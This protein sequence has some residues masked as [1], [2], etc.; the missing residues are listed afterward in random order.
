MP[1][2]RC[3]CKR[4]APWAESSS[5]QLLDANKISSGAPKKSRGSLRRITQEKSA[6][7][8]S[9][10]CS[11]S[12]KSWVRSSTESWLMPIQNLG[13]DEIRIRK[14]KCALKQYKID[15]AIQDLESWHKVFD[16]SWYLIY[17][18]PSSAIDTILQSYS[19]D[20]THITH[21]PIL[22]AQSL[23]T[24]IQSN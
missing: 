22:S 12:F 8:P 17:K 23:R 20:P 18:S 7:N 4:L 10:V 1:M 5:G 19:A 14:L 6:E 16:P 13:N 2:N 15:K 24:A 3:S 9:N 21:T 11:T